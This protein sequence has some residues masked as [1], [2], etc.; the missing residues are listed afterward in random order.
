[1]NNIYT[2][3]IKTHRKTGIKYFGQTKKSNPHKYKGSGYDWVEHIT[4]HGYDV[5]TEII[6]QCTDINERNYWG[7]YYSK[8]WNVVN[9]Q[10]DFGNKI[11]ANKI[12]ET[13]GG[14]G[15]RTGL[16]NGAY[17][18][19]PWNKGLTKKTDS[20]VA[21][22]AKSISKTTKGIRPAHNKGKPSPIKGI[23]QRPRPHMCG[24]NNPSNRPEVKAKI[25]AKLQGVNKG[26]KLPPRTAEHSKKISEGHAR[27]KAGIAP[28]L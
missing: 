19:I 16:K 1:M 4:E 25:S 27:K 11:W 20:R 2:L 26:R 18:K 8:L 14:P 23:K 9:A 5:D 15:G 28:A 22:Y 24:D 6:L 10:D 12:P 17:G 21:N 13:G 7:R 3:Y